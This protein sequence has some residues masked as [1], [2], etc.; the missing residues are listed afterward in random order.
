MFICPRQFALLCMACLPASSPAVCALSSPQQHAFHWHTPSCHKNASRLNKK[1][2][3]SAHFG[4]PVKLFL[5][6]NPRDLERKLENDWSQ[7]L[8]VK[9]WKNVLQGFEWC[10]NLEDK[11]S[12]RF[13]FQSR[14]FR[15]APIFAAFCHYVFVK[16][17]LSHWDLGA[18][19]RVW[20]S[21]GARNTK[22][23]AYQFIQTT[24]FGCESPIC[25]QWW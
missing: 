6:S 13:F 24:L 9:A 17:S 7:I 1:H 2:V 5:P 25:W 19:Q 4:I 10:G 15:I 21:D 11:S 22:K 14:Q 8:P 23:T 12:F 16:L 20:Q 18:W 3:C